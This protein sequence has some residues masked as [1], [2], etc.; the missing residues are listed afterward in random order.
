MVVRQFYLLLI[1]ISL[2][3]IDQWQLVVIIVALTT[4]CGEQTLF[5]ALDRQISRLVASRRLG[6]CCTGWRVISSEELVLRGDVSLMSL[7]VEIYH[8]LSLFNS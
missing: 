6:A 8:F 5:S 1:F 2:S 3:V 7:L 4:L